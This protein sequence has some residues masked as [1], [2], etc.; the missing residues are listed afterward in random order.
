MP[1]YPNQI[2]PS[3]LEKI[4]IIYFNT[5]SF[6]PIIFG[7]SLIG[8]GGALFLSENDKGGGLKGKESEDSS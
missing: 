2:F 1:F 3:F 8:G 6:E 7:F 5:N 4:I